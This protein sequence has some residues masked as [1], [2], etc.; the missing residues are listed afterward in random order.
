M[1]KSYTIG[2]V[3][4]LSML[5][6]SCGDVGDG[7]KP[8]IITKLAQ[9]GLICKTWEGSIQRGGF[10]SGTGVSG[11]AFDFTVEDPQVVKDLQAAM[12]QQLEVK[13]TYRTEFFTFCRSESGDHFVTKV[14]V[15]G[16]AKPAE[17]VEAPAAAVPAAYKS[18][19]KKEALDALIQQ[20]QQII[21][22]IEKM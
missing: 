4:S 20:N 3:A 5:L 16:K 6:A 15:M 19:T 17:A 8:G 2:V 22:I 7:Q 1:R 14:E 11:A 13:I 21:N 9:Q 10:N 12:D 18:M